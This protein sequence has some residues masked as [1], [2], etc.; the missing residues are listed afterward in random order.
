MDDEHFGKIAYAAYGQSADFK[1]YQGLPMPSWDDLPQQIRQ[2]W[3]LAAQ[4]VIEN[5]VEA[6]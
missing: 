6:G 1:N 2:S 4:A 3:V 5:H